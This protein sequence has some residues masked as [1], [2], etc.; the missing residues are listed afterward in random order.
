MSEYETLWQVFVSIRHFRINLGLKAG[1]V[2]ALAQTYITVFIFFFFDPL[3]T[4]IC[5]YILILPRICS[6]TLAVFQKFAH[7]LTDLI[8]FLFSCFLYC[9]AFKNQLYL[10]DLF[11][12]ISLAQ[13]LWS[14]ASPPCSKIVNQIYDH[15]FKCLSGP[16]MCIACF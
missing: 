12:S 8:E 16:L 3:T 2:I 5:A 14:A 10:S 1:V 4:R 9:R 7:E 15:V 11:T 13:V 6:C